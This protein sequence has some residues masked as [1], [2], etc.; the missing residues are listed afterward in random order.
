MMHD[1]IIWEYVPFHYRFSAAPVHMTNTKKIREKYEERGGR[2][3]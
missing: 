1:T 3:E 2:E